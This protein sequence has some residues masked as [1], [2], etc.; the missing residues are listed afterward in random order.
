MLPREEGAGRWRARR[1]VVGVSCAGSG[2]FPSESSGFSEGGLATRSPDPIRRA[3][4]EVLTLLEGLAGRLC[5]ESGKLE[6]QVS[7]RAVLMRG[8]SVFWT[9]GKWRSLSVQR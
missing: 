6:E 5:R 2:P 1:A 3:L 9:C 8:D 7:L 4:S